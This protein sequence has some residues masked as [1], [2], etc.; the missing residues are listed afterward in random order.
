VGLLKKMINGEY[1]VNMI[2][3][4]LPVTMQ[5]LTSDVSRARMR[6]HQCIR[7]HAAPSGLWWR[8]G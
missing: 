4:N 1:T 2:L 8:R 5:D 6:T 3:D 7:A